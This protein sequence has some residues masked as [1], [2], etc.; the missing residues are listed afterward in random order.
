M[1]TP[2][3]SKSEGETEQA[4]QLFIAEPRGRWVDQNGLAK[5][6]I[7]GNLKQCQNACRN[8]FLDS[9]QVYQDTLSGR[10]VYYI[11]P[12]S[13][14]GV[15]STPPHSMAEQMRLIDKV[16]S[17]PTSCMP[18][19]PPSPTHLPS[20]PGR[21]RNYQFLAKGFLRRRPGVAPTFLLTVSTPML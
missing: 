17:L 2:S 12:D 3:V 10:A 7:G 21:L 18:E 8:N 5:L 20:H 19:V 11:F 4:V 16:P 15:W 9:S 13:R 1:V 14:R 6:L